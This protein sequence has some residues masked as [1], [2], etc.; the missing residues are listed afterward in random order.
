MLGIK[1]QKKQDQNI[2]GEGLGPEEGEES[3]RAC[4]PLPGTCRCS[5]HSSHFVWLDVWP[6]ARGM[7]GLGN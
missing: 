3:P 4:A 5:S 1:W 7:P 2:A 6:F